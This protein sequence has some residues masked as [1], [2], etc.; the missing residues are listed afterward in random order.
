MSR[1][2][3]RK[4]LRLIERAIELRAQGYL[5]TEVATRLGV[6]VKTIQYWRRTNADFWG[7]R[8]AAAR[9]E[10]HDEIA[11]EAWSTL[12]RQMRSGDAK[13]IQ[14]SMRLLVTLVTRRR[15][16]AAQLV[17]SVP[18]HVQIAD[19]LRSLNDDDLRTYVQSHLEALTGGGG[20]CNR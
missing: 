3:P 20:D 15:P 19:H 1:Q 10:H 7:L 8:L 13:Q 14:E 11:D 5:C 16:D 9:A 6:H 2:P 18:E 17:P 4:K 12:R